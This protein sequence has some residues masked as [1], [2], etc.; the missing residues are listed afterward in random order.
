MNIIR[1]L[2]FFN[3][4]EVKE[5]VSI[6][7]VGAV[8]SHIA[9]NLA[10]LGIK[11]ITIYDFD[12]VEDHNIPNQMFFEDQIKMSK[13]DAV[14]T[15][16]LRINPDIII[17]IKEK[18]ENEELKGHVFIC[19]DSIDVRNKIYKNNEYNMDLITVYDTRIGLES[20]QVYSAIWNNPKHQK[21]IFDAS[22]F[23]KE[24]VEVPVSACGSK[25]AVLTTVQLAATFAT[26]NFINYLKTATLDNT[27]LFNSFSFFTKSFKF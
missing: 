10:R 6:I 14:K 9:N 21:G 25:L 2:E 7:G 4:I 12:N 3:P 8:G 11:E 23:K 5:K 27:I 1:H 17:N 19:V 16:L 18:Y 24:E 26:S 22:D 15:T 20:G 13:T